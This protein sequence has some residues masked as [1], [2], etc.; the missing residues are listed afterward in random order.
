MVGI[1]RKT[2]GASGSVSAEHERM[3]PAGFQVR[4]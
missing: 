2:S 3:H 4:M 1:L